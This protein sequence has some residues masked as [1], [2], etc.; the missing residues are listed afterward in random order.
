[1]INK[2]V[3]SFNKVVYIAPHLLTDLTP[4]ADNRCG[5]RGEGAGNILGVGYPVP[6]RRGILILG[7]SL[8]SKY[9]TTT[10]QII[11]KSKSEMSSSLSNSLVLY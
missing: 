3:D 6:V 1:M 7:V 10:K 2:G 11:Q 9:G 4:T 5:H 8:D